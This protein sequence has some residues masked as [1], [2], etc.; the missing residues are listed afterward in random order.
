MA[1]S[2]AFDGSVTYALDHVDVDSLRADARAAE[3]SRGMRFEWFGIFWLV[4]GVVEIAVGLAEATHRIG[5]GH[6]GN[7]YWMVFLGV[8]YL[9]LAIPYLIRA[10]RGPLFFSWFKPGVGQLNTL[11]WGRRGI[12]LGEAGRS[13]LTTT[14][15]AIASL[16]VGDAML[17][18]ARRTALPIAVPRSAFADG[19]SAFIAYV[20]DRIVSKRLLV[21]SAPAAPRSPAERRA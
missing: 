19:G 17:L 15:P 7:G 9:L 20:E 11:S 6:A 3:A 12:A 1:T 2:A 16:R 14:W 18:I 13:Q 21:R 5:R 4:L 10:R 8:A